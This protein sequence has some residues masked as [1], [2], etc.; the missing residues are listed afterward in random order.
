M[1]EPRHNTPE[2]L[3][4]SARRM[5]TLHPEMNLTERERIMLDRQLRLGAKAMRD[6]SD[7]DRQ[8]AELRGDAVEITR[9]A[10]AAINELVRANRI[11][12]SARL[13]IALFR[14][15]TKYGKD[16]AALLPPLS[17]DATDPDA[18]LPTLHDLRGI[19]E[20]K[21]DDRAAK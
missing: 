19:L 13:R 1:S 16:L 4:A 3:E 7:R 2:A 9:V 18:G 8:L 12:D 5:R 15:Q 11:Q 20:P 21:E 6:L 10:H 17:T 14:Y